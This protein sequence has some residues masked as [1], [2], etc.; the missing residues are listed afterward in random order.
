[1]HQAEQINNGRV[2]SH[3]KTVNNLEV[4]FFFFLAEL[5]DSRKLMDSCLEQKVGMTFM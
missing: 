3:R 2:H 5:C 4:L 1:M